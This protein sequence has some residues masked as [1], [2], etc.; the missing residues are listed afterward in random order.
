MSL[1]DILIFV[2]T[3][4]EIEL[5]IAGDGTGR[6]EL[7]AEATHCHAPV[8]FLGWRDDVEALYRQADAFLLTSFAEGWPFVIVEAAAVGLPIIMTDVGSSGESIINNQSGLVVAINNKEA[9][10][11]A[12]N[13]LIGDKDLRDKLGKGA[14]D[15][16]LKLPGQEEFLKLYKKSWE[17]AMN[18]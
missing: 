13:K 4:P 9:L 5:W 3:Y 14:K 1:K 12:M 18:N 15:A 8:R 11:K 2:K 6:E 17:K 16:V 10:I 7:K